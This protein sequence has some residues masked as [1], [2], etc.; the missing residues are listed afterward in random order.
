MKWKHKTKK[1]KSYGGLKCLFDL[2]VG[3]P[4][5]NNRCAQIRH[6][7]SQHCSASSLFKVSALLLSITTSGC[8]TRWTPKYN[9]KSNVLLLLLPC[10]QTPDF[11]ADLQQVPLWMNM[12]VQNYYLTVETCEYFLCFG[13]II[14]IVRPS[15]AARM[16]SLWGLLSWEGSM[17][18]L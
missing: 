5:A 9:R 17:F 6:P 7:Y 12:Q 8:K 16:K 3:E 13:S 4:R 10:K 15:R 1:W 18:F 2:W 14:R 11:L